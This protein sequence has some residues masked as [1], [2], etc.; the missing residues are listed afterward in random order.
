VGQLFRRVRR[1]VV[2]ATGNEQTPWVSEALVGE[3]YLN[4]NT[5][6]A[7]LAVLPSS[8]RPAPQPQPA[9]A[10]EPKAAASQA[11]AVPAITPAPPAAQAPAR[12]LIYA[13]QGHTGSVWS[14]A[15]SPDGRRIVSGSYDNSLRLWDAS[16][17]KQLGPPLQGDTSWVRSVAFSPDGRRIVSGSVDK[18][19]R[20][21][22]AE[23]GAPHGFPP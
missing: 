16:S 15:F 23:T 4:Q 13:L 5:K 21:W 6:P 10:Q 17:G 12:S 3:V 20:L 18:T 14:V 8:P 11:P 22:D 9:A 7:T 19:L 1:D 2:Q